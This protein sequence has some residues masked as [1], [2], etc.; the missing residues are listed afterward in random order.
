MRIE[1][2][3]VYINRK[4]ER[5]KNE[6]PEKAPKQTQTIY[7]NLN[8]IAHLFCAPKE[9]FDQRLLNWDQICYL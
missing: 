6:R 4:C 2:H 5:P 1:S 7:N 9:L 3:D 8:P